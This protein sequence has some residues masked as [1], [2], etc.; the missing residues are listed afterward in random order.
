MYENL[1]KHYKIIKVKN[2]FITGGAGYIASHCVVSLVKNGYN[3][4]ILDNF[5]NSHK[6]VIKKLE[7]IINKKVT[8]YK[9][10]IRDKKKLKSIFKKT[11]VPCCNSLC[12]FQSSE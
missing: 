12:R 1:N 9:V 11:P 5:S 6:T 4:I 10:D 3:P 8:F 7:I 2:I